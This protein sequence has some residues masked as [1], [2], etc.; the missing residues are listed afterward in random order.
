M[1]SSSRSATPVSSGLEAYFNWHRRERGRRQPRRNEMDE[2]DQ[3][4]TCTLEG[5][6]LVARRRAWQQVVSRATNRRVEDS[7]VEATYPMDA[8]LLQ[9]LRDRIAAEA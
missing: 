5:D 9:E 6:Q 4:L 3:A 1:L 2:L 8:R 7:R